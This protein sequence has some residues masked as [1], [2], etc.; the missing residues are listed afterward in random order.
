L[1]HGARVNAKDDKNST[2]LHAAA[3][4]GRVEVLE[5]L[6]KAGADLNAVNSD[7]ETPYDAATA[8]WSTELQGV[9]EFFGG[10]LKLK[11]DLKAIRVSRPKAAEL[12]LRHGGKAGK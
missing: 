3:F 1:H 9:F 11:L 7:G 12:L 2:A 6:V 8:P 4:F 10:V 5:V